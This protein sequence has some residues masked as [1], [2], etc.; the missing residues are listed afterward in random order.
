MEIHGDRRISKIMMDTEIFDNKKSMD[1]TFLDRI[2]NLWNKLTTPYANDPDEARREYTTRVIL[3]IVSA[4]AFLATPVLVVAWVGGMLEPIT[5]LVGIF[6][7]IIFGGGLWLAY[8]GYWRGVSYIPP[9]TVFLIGVLNSYLDGLGSTAMSFFAVAIV[10]TVMLQG[11]KAQWVMVILCLSAYLGLG[12][13]HAQG[14]LP[15][16]APRKSL[17][18]EWAIDV[19]VTMVGLALLSWFLITQF[20]NTLAQSKT[21]ATELESVRDSLEEQVETRTLELQ[22]SYAES[23]HL[24]QQILESQQQ[25]IRELSTPVIPVINTSNGSGGVIVMPLVG[26]IDRLRARDITRNLL[27]GISQHKAKIVIIDLTGVSLM[28]TG[29][30]N[31]LN[32]TI[33]AARL[34]GAQT[35]VTGIS[36]AVAE[37]IVELGIDWS[38]ITTL[39][40]LQTGLVVALDSLG[41]RLTS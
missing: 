39:S 36:D 22:E 9:V 13:A 1:Q 19:I 21:Y 4:I 37:S 25:M 27:A 8:R 24:H 41:V 23:E 28:D 38:E 34:K 33:Q 16:I 7:S 5:M 35:I 6:S 26:S 14:Y 29:I 10:L 30:V 11:I 20:K 15:P 18:M 40:D 3:F 32:K 12:W 31:H 17:L 2:Q